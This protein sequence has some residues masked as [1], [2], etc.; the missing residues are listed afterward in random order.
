[1]DFRDYRQKCRER[2]GGDALK[3][4]L[5]NWRGFESLRS[6][7]TEALRVFCRDPFLQD[8]AGKCH[9]PKGTLSDFLWKLQSALQPHKGRL[10]PLLD[11]EEHFQKVFLRRGLIIYCHA[12]L[13]EMEVST[14]ADLKQ[15]LLFQKLITIPEDQSQIP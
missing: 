11:F 13:H 15:L 14:Q 7:L 1:M 8:L 6:D 9:N 5:S 10:D 4:A 12:L 3:D 2:W